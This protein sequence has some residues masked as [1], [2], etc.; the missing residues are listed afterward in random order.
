MKL[1]PQLILLTGL[2]LSALC[3][4][5]CASTSIRTTDIGCVSAR[6]HLDKGVATY[7]EI[8]INQ[9]VD[10]SAP[11]MLLRL[12]SGFVISRKSFTY[13]ALKKAG[14]VGMDER[15]YQPGSQYTHELKRYGASFL[16]SNGALV[17]LRLSQ[18]PGEAVG[19]ARDHGKRFYTLPMSQQEIEELFGHPD[20]VSDGFSLPK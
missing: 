18:T 9:P 15:D 14:F 20:K 13:V 16:F 19:I 6:A 5:G 7:Y 11:P 12:P 17:T 10:A 8:E 3:L 1:H 2:C 4:T